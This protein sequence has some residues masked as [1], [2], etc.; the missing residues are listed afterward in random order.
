MKLIALEGPSFA[1]KSTLGAQLAAHFS[2]EIIGEHHDYVSNGFPTGPKTNEE[3]HVNADFFLGLEKRRSADIMKALGRHSLLFSDRSVVS[4]VAFQLA[5]ASS[6]DKD[7]RAIAVP[8]YAIECAQ[9]EIEAGNIKV[10]DGILLIRTADE[11]T[12]NF[13]VGERGRT[14]TDIFNQY[15][16]S[17]AISKATELACTL[18]CPYTPTHTIISENV[19]ESR[20]QNLKDAISFIEHIKH[21]AT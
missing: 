14:N 13:R 4:L 17:Q 16:F 2:T 9:Q 5:L 1:G 7:H 15:S 19:K 8:D 20:E 18:I 3:A 21:W 11:E 6:P 10:P 12:H